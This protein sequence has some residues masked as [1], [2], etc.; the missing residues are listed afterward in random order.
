MQAGEPDRPQKYMGNPQ[1][2]PLAV[3]QCAVIRLKSSKVHNQTCDSMCVGPPDA[4]GGS[5][6][7]V[8]E[9]PKRQ[10]SLQ[11]PGKL[12]SISVQVPFP[13]P[14]EHV[15]AQSLQPHNLNS[16]TRSRWSREIPPR[17][18]NTYT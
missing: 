7:T 10:F 6:V 16:I 13:F 8:I 5:T 4:N 18:E 11:G 17:G 1:F 3:K 15:H 9:E 14:V 12:Q 2:Q